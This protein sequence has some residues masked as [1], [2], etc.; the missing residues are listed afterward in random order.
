MWKVVAAGAAAVLI[1][2]S[3]IVFAQGSVKDQESFHFVAGDL[4]TEAIG[5]LTDARMRALKAVLQLTPAHVAL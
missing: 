5:T 1:T 2:G 4:S 3:T